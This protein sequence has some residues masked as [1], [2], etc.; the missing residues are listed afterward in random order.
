M[1]PTVCLWAFCWKSVLCPVSGAEGY[2][3]SKPYQVKTGFLRGP[4]K[5]CSCLCLPNV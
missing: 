4:C 1:D 3:Q 5:T 2:R